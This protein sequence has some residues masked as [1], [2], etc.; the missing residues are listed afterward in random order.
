M[1]VLGLECPVSSFA[2]PLMYGWP[3]FVWVYVSV[4]DLWALILPGGCRESEDDNCE[5]DEGMMSG[6]TGGGGVVMYPD[7]AVGLDEPDVNV[8][9]EAEGEMEVVDGKVA[10]SF[11]LGVSPSE[12]SS[13][14][15]PFV[16]RLPIL[17]LAPVPLRV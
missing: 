3:R 1:F 9:A 8:V 14:S 11:C 17:V 4:A 12:G 7:E 10:I 6:C 5:E 13:L 2:Y 16:N 15:G